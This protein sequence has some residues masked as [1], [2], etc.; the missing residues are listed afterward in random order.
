MDEMVRRAMARWPNV[1]AVF[2]WLA[3]DRRGEWHVR[4]GE[5]DPHAFDRITSPQL[6]AFIRRNYGCDERGRY[7]FQNGPQRVFVRL[8]Y[9][10]WVLRLD[11]R[12]AG[13]VTHTDAPVAGVAAAFLDENGALI[14]LTE[15]GPGIVLDRDLE[16][17]FDR[18]RD[19]AG[20]PVDGDALL[21]RVGAGEPVAVMLMR[22]TVRVASI[23]SNAVE[24]R[25]AFVRDPRPD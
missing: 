24:A 23:R 6:V 21:A 25:F 18:M 7:F 22:W 17:V 3:L 5:A 10:P 14:L 8:D 15:H 11:D 1:P 13:L 4:L 2:G 16:A 9:L 19:D 20:V 12:S